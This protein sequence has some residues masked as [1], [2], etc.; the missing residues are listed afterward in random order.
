M[1]ELTFENLPSAV[2]QLTKKLEN[3][4]RLLLNR[5]ESQDNHPDQLLTI[6]EAAK[7]LRLTKPTLYG[8]VSK[9][10][11]PVMKLKGSKRLYF[12]RTELM[13]LAKEGRRETVAE[14]EANAGN[15]LKKKK[16]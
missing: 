2:N 6:D 9:G 4:E 8:K 10:E 16:G 3:I 5:T 12:S 14:I 13:E 15:G 11:L 7:L 1:H